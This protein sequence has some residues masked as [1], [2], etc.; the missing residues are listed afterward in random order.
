[1]SDHLRR[2]LGGDGLQRPD[3]GGRRGG[4]GLRRIGRGW[5][6]GT[7]TVAADTSW[8]SICPTADTTDTVKTYKHAEIAI[9]FQN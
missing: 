3:G 1:V 7:C 6:F 5:G 2:G 4:G 9:H 8:P